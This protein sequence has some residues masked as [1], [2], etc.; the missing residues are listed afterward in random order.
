MK[1]STFVAITIAIIA[2]PALLLYL[3]FGFCLWDFFWPESA[4]VCSRLMYVLFT[5]SS[6]FVTIPAVI[7]LYET[8]QEGKK[9]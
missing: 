7:P 1:R 3:A 9:R 4:G 6:L 2:A 8:Y 5:L